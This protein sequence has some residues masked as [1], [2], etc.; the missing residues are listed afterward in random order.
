MNETVII[1]ET[2]KES[3]IVSQVEPPIVL[4]TIEQGPPGPP[5]DTNLAVTRFIAETPST[6]WKIPH[7][8]NTRFLHIAIYKSDGTV[9]KAPYRFIDD[10][11]VSIDFT[12]PISGHVDII[13]GLGR[14]ETI[15][16]I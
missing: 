3:V 9:V 8:R 4:T 11:N 14:L 6:E 12:Y 16:V 7:Y 1:L 13:F 10:N 15:N 5:G 2:V